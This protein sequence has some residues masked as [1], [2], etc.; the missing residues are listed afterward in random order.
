MKKDRCTCMYKV[1]WVGII[2]FD[3]MFSPFNSV[4]LLIA[5]GLKYLQFKNVQLFKDQS[6]DFM[7]L[8]VK[9]NVT[10]SSVLLKSF[11]QLYLI[12]LHYIKLY[13]KESTDC[14]LG[15]LSSSVSS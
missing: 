3:P 8:S 4:L 11:I 13:I 12:Q 15:A 1:L 7:E 2:D 14:L 5:E 6:L 9:Q 10:T